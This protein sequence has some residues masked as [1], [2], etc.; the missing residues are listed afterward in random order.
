MQALSTTDLLL[1]PLVV[2][3]AEEMFAILSE[4]E[5]YR[6]L[7]YPPPP[8]L[9]HLREVYARVEGRKSPDG[10]ELW[11]NWVVRPPGQ[12]AIGYVQ[13]T[14][15]SNIAWVGFVFSSKQWGR[16]FASQAT[17]AV[18][19]HACANLGVTRFLATV[20]ADNQR[21]VRLLERLGFREAALEEQRTHELSATERLFAR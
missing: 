12:A 7:D 1:E 13:L 10:C 21:S 9:E 2:A 15:T 3:H 18:I 8:S 17:Q 14:I 11:L 20:E 6:Y 5:L 4:P 16:G 19:D